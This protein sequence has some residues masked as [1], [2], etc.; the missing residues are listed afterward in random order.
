[1]LIELG[2]LAV[3]TFLLDIKSDLIAN[4]GRIL[5]K[6][7]EDTVKIIDNY[8]KSHLQKQDNSF[9]LDSSQQN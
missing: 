2:P 3:K 4:N 8:C 5:G 7:H 9:I 1:M 6:K